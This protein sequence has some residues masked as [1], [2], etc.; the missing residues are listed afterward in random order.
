MVY[1]LGTK[2]PAMPFDKMRQHWWLPGSSAIAAVGAPTV[3]EVK[4]SDAVPFGEFL[5]Q[6]GFTFSPTQNRITD[7]RDA[8]R[9]ERTILGHKS[10][11]DLAVTA[12][13]NTNANPAEFPNDFFEAMEEGEF[14][15]MIRRTGKAFD[16]PLAVGDIVD[17]LLVQVGMKSPVDGDLIFSKQEYAVHDFELGVAVVAGA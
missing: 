5:Q 2:V 8:D 1:T 17:V 13:D 14:G 7:T 15:W 9:K 11:G 10:P 4:V 3:A 6:N 12:V 16:A